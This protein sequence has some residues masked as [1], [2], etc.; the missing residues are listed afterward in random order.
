MNL[1]RQQM[2]EDK[3]VRGLSVGTRQ[4]YMHAVA[5]LANFHDR[6]PKARLH[7]K[8]AGP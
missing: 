7:Q 3:T 4:R 5:E 1:L 6:P 8:N 2:L